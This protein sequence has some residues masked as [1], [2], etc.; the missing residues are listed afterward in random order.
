[1][2]G[3]TGYVISRSTVLLSYDAARGTFALA[4]RSFSRASFRDRIRPRWNFRN[5]FGMVWVALPLGA[6]SVLGSLNGNMPRYFIEK[7]WGP[8]DLGIFSALNYIPTAAV[9]VS[10]ALGYAAFARLA[11]LY[12]KGDL[13]GFKLV[14]AKA[15]AVCGGLGVAG[16]LGSAVLGRQIL[17]ILY[18]P[19]YADHVD[20]L[21]W[22]MAVGAVG[23]V[24]SCLGCAM[25]AA[26]QFRPQVP[27]FIVVTGSSFL[28][29]YLLIPWR[30][31]L[32]AA[33]AALV[34]MCVQLLGTSFI[35][36]RAIAK[37][38]RDLKPAV[39]IS[40]EPALESQ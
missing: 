29:C 7:N 8:S 26:A 31:L 16:L 38:A 30:G 9:M 5:Q 1:M 27:L 15:V 17:T 36:Y 2:W 11:K 24:A 40:I 28:A 39:N 25:S 10:T 13:G 14:L 21:M 18:R 23:C 6:V 35:I 37:R 12:F 32:G 4:G 3:V 20:L 22:L 34:S 19:Q 33:F